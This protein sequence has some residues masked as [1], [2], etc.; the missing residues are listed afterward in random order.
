MSAAA[1]AGYP[2]DWPAIALAVKEAAG[3]CCER[4]GARHGAWGSR[5]RRGG[6][7]EVTPAAMAA[8]GH[9]KP[10]FRRRLSRGGYVRVVE[11]VLACAHIDQVPSHCTPD[12]LACWCQR[13][14]LLHDVG[15][16]ARNA[17]ATRRARM[18]TL[19]L[20]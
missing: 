17:A 6:F 16:H 19:E 11:V 14:H 18:G 13:C 15:Q 2:P 10:P 20:F 9:G 8:L 4:C 12:N 7:I 5:D 1:R 3:W